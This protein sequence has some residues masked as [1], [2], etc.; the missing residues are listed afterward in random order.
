MVY[1]KNKNSLL[2]KLWLFVGLSTGLWSLG[3]GMEVSSDSYNMALFWNKIL[4]LGAIVVPTFFLHFV[5]VLLGRNKVQKVVINLGYAL[6]ALFIFF[7][8]YGTLFVKGVPPSS[9]FNYWVEPGVL[10]YWYFAYFVIYFSYSAFLLIRFL[11]KAT[12]IK[13]N[14]ARYVLFALIAG[15]GGG[16]TNFFPQFIQIYPFGTYLVFFYIIFITYAITR[17]RLMDI[18]MLVK[19]SSV[20]TVLVVVVGS[21]VLILTSAISFLVERVSGNNARYISAVIVAIVVTILFPPL[22]SILERVTD[23]F[24]FAKVYN[25]SILLEKINDI[26]SS[27]GNSEAILHAVIKELEDAFHYTCISIVLADKNSQLKIVEQRGFDPVVLKKFVK[28]KEKVLPLY[29]ETSREIRVIDEMRSRYESGEYQPRSVDL[30]YELSNLDIA[31]VIPL[32]SKYKMI[33]LIAMGSKRSGNPFSQED[34]RILEVISSQLGIA[35]DNTR[36]YEEVQEFASTLKQKVDE[37]TLDLTKQADHLKK[38]LKMRSEFL[39]IAS[40]QLKTPVS[41]IL[42]TI[43]MFREGSMDKLPKE[44]QQKFFDNIFWKAKKLNVIISDILRASEMDTDDFTLDPENL[45]PVAIEDVLQEVY[46][47]NIDEAQKRGLQLI[48]EKPNKSTSTVLTDADFFEQ[49]IFNLVDDA[50]KYTK[51]GSVKMILTQE[52][53]RV[54]IKIVDTGI[55]I[56]KEEQ[57]KIF[58]KFSRA[59]NAVNMYTDGSGL[60]LFIVKKIIEAHQGGKISF[61]SELGKGTVFTVSLQVCKDNCQTEIKQIKGVKK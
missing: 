13:K 30:L 28:G 33:G 26:T 34:L 52:K 4:Y 10:Y 54:V 39:D 19:R 44:Q 17:Y 49:A 59:S 31:L 2:N 40:H 8:F 41:V 47:D 25:P 51:S 11:G 56:P 45:R 16:V 58:D 9:G 46:N 18:R 37:Q 20:F 53:G 1:F 43:S 36:L 48:L 55:G 57:K 12:G 14:Q 21:L 24:L 3:L 35:I 7:N 42:G 32:F 60:G 50:I 6:S 29:F 38:L 61:E 27:I 15:A 23:R 5:C 22:K